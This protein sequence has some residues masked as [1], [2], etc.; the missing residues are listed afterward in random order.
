MPELLR[1]PLRLLVPAVVRHWLKRVL[2]G[3]K[4]TPEI[5]AVRFGDLRRVT[6]ICPDFGHGRG[7][8]VDRVYVESFL[9]GHRADIRGKVLELGDRVYTGRFGG[10]RVTQSD[11]LHPAAGNPVATIVA[12]LQTGD[13]VPVG[14]YD[15]MIVT[16]ALNVI[17]DFRSALRHCLRTLRPGGVLLMTTPTITQISMPDYE[18]AWGEH[19]RFTPLAVKRLLG[20]LLPADSFTTREYGNVLAAISF[21]HGLSSAE[22]TRQELDY[23]DPEFTMITGARAVMPG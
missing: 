15:C 5:G 12:D 1:N 4:Y 17:F 16:Q 7:Q 22:L 23:F 13:N 8:A 18:A 21:L 2:L 6:P 11:V 19:W 9:E 14:E 20:E 3:E 10:D